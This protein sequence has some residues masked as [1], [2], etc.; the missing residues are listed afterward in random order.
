[1]E[2]LWF[3]TGLAVSILSSV[4]LIHFSTLSNKIDIG[5]HSL[6]KLSVVD[7]E[8]FYHLVM[9][10][11]GIVKNFD[12]LVALN[13]RHQQLVLVVQAQL[14]SIDDK[15]YTDLVH[16]LLETYRLKERQL[17]YY[18]SD[19]ATLN[20]AKIYIAEKVKGLSSRP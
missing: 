10:H 3:A 11:T 12:A 13:N 16:N 14:L 19:I 17:E 2:K 1:M 9:I 15:K 4:F 8:V 20:N 7:E 6:E 5:I 18:K